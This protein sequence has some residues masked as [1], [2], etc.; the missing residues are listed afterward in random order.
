M[1][2]STEN[3]LQNRGKYLSMK[4]TND[5]NRFKSPVKGQMGAVQNTGR[6]VIKKSK[7]HQ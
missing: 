6:F 7:H 3:S 4:D 2:R 1:A 5:M